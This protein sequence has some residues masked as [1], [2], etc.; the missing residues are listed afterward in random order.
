[1]FNTISKHCLLCLRL[2]SFR[3]SLLWS[4]FIRGGVGRLCLCASQLLFSLLLLFVERTL[5]DDECRCL[6]TYLLQYTSVQILPPVVRCSLKS[7][8]VWSHKMKEETSPPAHSHQTSWQDAFSTS[9]FC[10]VYMKQMGDGCYL[11]PPFKVSL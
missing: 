2:V 1:M 11:P 9:P 4:G 3:G 10:E 8:S 5:L 7:L 6:H